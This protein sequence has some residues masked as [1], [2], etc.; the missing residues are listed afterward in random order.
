MRVILLLLV[1]LCGIANAQE[2]P[3][4]R[5]SIRLAVYNRLNLA[6]TGSDVATTARVNEA[7]N[8]AI[9]Q[10]CRQY[11]AVEK[12]DTVVLYSIIEGAA[13]N[14]D[15]LRGHWAFRKAGD[16]ARY[17]MQY[18]PM[19]S[20]FS[21]MGGDAI[22][23]GQKLG[24][25]LSPRYWYSFADRFFTYPFVQANFT[26]P[27]S[28]IVMYYADGQPLTSDV[29]RT[30]IQ[31]EYRDAL[32]YL[33]CAKVSEIRKQFEEAASFYAASQRAAVVPRETE[34]KR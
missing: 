27:D 16:S 10:I 9:S 33:T 23:Q 19:D 2:V 25:P 21:A 5:D 26:S 1:L 3:A 4:R 17:A 30:D 8:A 18:K 32:I 13:L 20:L 34:G 7:I 22:S 24:D 11:P 31:K 6:S 29:S 14:S 28:F 15:Y 12:I